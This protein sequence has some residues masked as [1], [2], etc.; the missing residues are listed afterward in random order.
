MKIVIRTCIN[1]T[2]ADL[3]P[4]VH[5][6]CMT[7]RRDRGPQARRDRDP[8]LLPQCRRTNAD[9]GEDAGSKCSLHHNSLTAQW[10]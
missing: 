3:K 10:L 4:P 5:F 1:Q 9:S 8:L 7:G 2:L 6:G